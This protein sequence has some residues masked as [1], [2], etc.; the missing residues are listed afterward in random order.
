MFVKCVC[1]CACD[2]FRE[3]NQNVFREHKVICGSRPDVF[4]ASTCVIEY[5]S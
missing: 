3:E 2:A 4:Y 5:S 1:L